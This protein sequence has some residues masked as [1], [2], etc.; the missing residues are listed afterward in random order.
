MARPKKE[1]T[2]AS[3]VKTEFDKKIEAA[4]ASGIPVLFVNRQKEDWRL[5]EGS[6]KALW[7]KFEK[8]E[9]PKKDK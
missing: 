1:T 7:D 2:A 8:I 6:A 9:N 5:S 4:F 3:K